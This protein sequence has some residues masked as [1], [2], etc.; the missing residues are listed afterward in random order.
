MLD[1][2]FPLGIIQAKIWL[3]NATGLSR[4]AL[5]VYFALGLFIVAKLVWRGRFGTFFALAVV[6]IGALFGEWVDHRAEVVRTVPCLMSEHLH[7]I[8]NTLF[9]PILLAIALPWL[10]P[11]APKQVD[12]NVEEDAAT[13]PD[14]R[15]EMSGKNAERRLEQA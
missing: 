15:P 14:D 11:R 3:I 10:A 7:D 4:D 2:I 6:M 13:P 8:R 9:G 5:H 12:Q 1:S